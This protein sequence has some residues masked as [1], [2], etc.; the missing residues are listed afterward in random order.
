MQYQGINPSSLNDDEL[1]SWRDAYQIMLSRTAQL[2]QVGR[3]RLRRNQAD[4]L[5]AVAVPDSTSLWLVLWVRWSAKSECF[6]VVPR[7]D[8]EWDAHASYHR[9]GW[10]NGASVIDCWYFDSN[11][12]PG[13][14]LRLQVNR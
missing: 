1:A 5:F 3:M 13:Y 4:Q 12:C 9:D 14:H 11:P 7:N 8:R 2:R 10:L 6:V